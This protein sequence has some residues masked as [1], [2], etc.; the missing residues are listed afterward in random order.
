M[1][2]SLPSRSAVVSPS[3]GDAPAGL[4]DPVVRLEALTR[5]FDGR[6]VVGPLDLTVSVG[7]R[8]ALRGPNGSGKSTVLRCIAGSVIPTSGRALVRG[9]TAGTLAARALVGVSLSQERSFDLRLTGHANLVLFA[10]LR[11]FSARAAGRVV[12]ELEEELELGEIAAQWVAKCSTGMTQQ[13][14]FARALL[15]EP[16]L[17]LLDEPTRSLDDEARERLW[18]ALGRRPAAAVLIATHRP[19]DVADCGRRIDLAH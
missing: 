8:V 6:R 17:L 2:P 11:G 12:A 19:E 14:S 18:L 13:L 3:T 5:D 16:P 4:R 10:Q 9:H 15:G 1:T 7:E